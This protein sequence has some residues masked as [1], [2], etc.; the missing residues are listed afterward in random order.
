MTKIDNFNQQQFEDKIAFEVEDK[1]LPSISYSLVSRDGMLATGT[2]QRKGLNHQFTDKTRFRIAS[3]TKMFTSI[4]LMQLVE[5]GL[6]DLDVDVSNYL[7]DFRP[8]NPFSGE[9]AGPLGDEVTLRKL[10]S[11]TAGMVREPKS[12]HYLDD[13]NPPLEKTVNELA[14]SVLKNDP[15]AGIFSY[16]N[17]GM[18]VVGSVVERVSGQTYADYLSENIL[19]PLG[20][21][22]SSISSNPT[23]LANLAPAYMWTVDSD[24]PAPVFDLGGFPAGNIYS[25][26]SDMSR[27]MICLLRGGFTPEGHRIVSPSS[28]EQMWTVVGHRPQGYPG[29]SDYGLGFG[30]SQLD[31]WRSVGHGGA[32]YGFASQISLLPLAGLAIEIISTM[33]MTNNIV[34]HLA[35]SGLRMAL[36]AMNMGSPP[37][38]RR[39][40]QKVSTEHFQTLPGHYKNQENNEIVEIIERNGK[41]FLLGDGMPL[42]IKPKTGNQFGVDGRLYGEGSDYEFLDLDFSLSGKMIWKNQSWD[43][44]QVIDETPV[45]PELEPHLGTYGPDI[46]ITTLSFQN[47]NLTCLIEYFYSHICTPL[48]NNRFKMNG[49]LYPDEILELGANDENGQPG[50]RVGPMFLARRS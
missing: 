1:N 15:S 31:A 22:D 25:T 40:Y 42:Q 34:N 28:L 41:L 47:G 48:G 2:M 29:L 11:H 39:T 17:A 35:D 5:Q 18:A 30:V 36:A 32:V 9:N 38:P 14:S 4:C 44:T 50:I 45:D 27:Y 13:S 49:S 21:S 26:L 37:M 19:K 33:D 8:K 10:M 43:K 3:Q 20:M 12:G 16:S 23:I 24:V 6:I 7:P 46:N